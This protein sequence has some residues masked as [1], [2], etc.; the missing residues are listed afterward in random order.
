MTDLVT[1]I[2]QALV[3]YQMLEAMDDPVFWAVAAIFVALWYANK[4]KEAS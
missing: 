4:D 2:Y 1:G 3:S